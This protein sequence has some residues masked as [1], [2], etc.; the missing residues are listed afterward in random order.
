[1][2][3]EMAKKSLDGISPRTLRL[4]LILG[5]A[6]VGGLGMS[7]W[8]VRTDGGVRIA[9][10]VSDPAR[11]DERREAA[12]EDGGV[13]IVGLVA[14]PVG[15]DGQNEEVTIRNGS[16]ATVALTG[17]RVRDLSNRTWSL[18]ELG[19]IAAG[20]TKTIQRRGKP[21]WLNNNG[22]TIDLLD[23]HGRIV[24]QVTYG[25]V[26]EGEVVAFEE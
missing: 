20:E 22:E 5:L 15:D 25:K 8:V 9:S 23:E 2:A 10:S 3:A 7:F 13:R 14:D 19:S 6:A 17:W 18:A 26:A 24:H 1:M 12:R 16:G 21:M 11:D 4:I